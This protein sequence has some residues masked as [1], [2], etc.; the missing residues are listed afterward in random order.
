M[1]YSNKYFENVYAFPFGLDTN[2]KR[3]P[4]RVRFAL[5]LFGFKNIKDERK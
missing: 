1:M 2:Y 4:L 3:L 5:W